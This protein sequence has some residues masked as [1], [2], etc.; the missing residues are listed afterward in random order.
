MEADCYNVLL[1]YD[2]KDK[3]IHQNVIACLSRLDPTAAKKIDKTKWTGRLIVKKNADLDTAKRLK[4]FLQDSGAL[5]TV[6]KKTS[7]SFS[8]DRQSQPPAD[9]RPAALPGVN[10]VVTTCPN[11]GLEQFPGTECQECGIIFAKVRPR[12][13]NRQSHASLTG[14]ELSWYQKSSKFT[15]KV[16]QIVHPVLPLFE[17]IRH[18]MGTDNFTS[19]AQRVA[20]RMISC[21]IVLVIAFIL[22]VGSLSLGK[23]LWFLYISMPIG[24]N[25]ILIFPERAEMFR[26]I[27]DADPLILGWDITMAALYVVLLLG[28]IAQ[29]MHLIRYFYDPQGV[30]GKLCL[31]ISPFTA[32]T[33]WAI[34]QQPPYPEYALAV[35]L[36]VIPVLCILGSCLRLVQAVLPEIGDLRKAIDFIRR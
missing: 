19:W 25:F 32:G 5:C 10:R 7:A 18:P 23:M 20:D 1:S 36:A 14:K 9:R 11:C 26:D 15:Q 30:I 13:S 8:A 28:C 31:W 29:I 17:K 3:E 24:Q 22:Q 16:R 35:T 21:G 12:H 2:P 33:A 6:Q 34:S 4:C 27:V